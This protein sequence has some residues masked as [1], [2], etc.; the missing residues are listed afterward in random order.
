MK[1]LFLSHKFYP[2]I[3]GIE[4]HSEI[5]ANAFWNAGNEVHLLTWTRK[6]G[7]SKFPY[8]II[9]NPSIYQKFRECL[10]ADV[11][12]ENNVA[13]RLSWPLLFIHRPLIIALHTWL[14]RVNG[15][16]GFRDKIKYRWMKRA[17]VVISCSDVIRRKCW[18]DSVVINNPYNDEIFRQL[19]GIDKTIDFVFLGRLVSDKGV[20]LAIHS[21]HRLRNSNKCSA[22]LATHAALTIIGEGPERSVLE[23]LVE[24]LQL[25][26]CIHFKGALKGE[27]LVQ[28]LNQHRYI[29]VPSKWEEP[30][31]I[32]A[33]EGMASGCIPIVSNGGGLPEAIG[34]AGLV[35]A[36]GDINSLVSTICEVVSNQ[37]LENRL[38]DNGKTHLMKYKQSVIALQYL[39][40]LEQVFELSN[41]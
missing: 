26:H 31:G 15:K 37:D 5:I 7:T 38:R 3:G 13:L 19:S 32:V 1:I 24:S 34:N 2:D 10:W 11:I 12:F 39:Q 27:E 8:T 20:D 4:T 9:R 17:R 6:T 25:K 18:P 30:F 23:N 16:V 14:T 41:L 40:V 35:F 33:L 36:R 28:C 21:I 29:L 22:L